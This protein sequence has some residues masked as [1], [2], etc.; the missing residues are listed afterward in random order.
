MIKKN[1]ADL[2]PPYPLYLYSPLSHTETKIS[3]TQ[4]NKKK[5]LLALNKSIVYAYVCV[6]QRPFADPVYVLT[7][8]CM[9]ICECA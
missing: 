9:F 5:R 4:I 7:C 6:Q 3:Y 8:L 1:Q 2:L